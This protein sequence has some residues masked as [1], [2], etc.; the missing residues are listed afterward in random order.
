MKKAFSPIRDERG[1]AV[2]EIAFALPTVILFIWGIFQLGIIFQANAGMQHALGEGA[3]LAT[4]C[5]NPTAAGVCST[6]PDADIE[7]RISETLFGTGLGD[8]DVEV[9]RPTDDPSTPADESDVD[10][11]TLTATFSMPTNFLFFE[12]PD[13]DLTRSKVVYVAG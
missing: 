8:F 5:L 4:I 9:S 2:I 12:G 13:L 11:L 10:Y 3:R 7:E 6:A 1:A